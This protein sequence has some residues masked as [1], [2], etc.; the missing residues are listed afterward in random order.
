MGSGLNVYLVF[1]S[2][3]NIVYCSQPL[4]FVNVV[5][6]CSDPNLANM[7][8]LSKNF[9]GAAWRRKQSKNVYFTCVCCFSFHSFFF[10]LCPWRI[11]QSYAQII[12]LET[13]QMSSKMLQR[14]GE[15]VSLRVAMSQKKFMHAGFCV[16]VAR[17]RI[18]TARW[19]SALA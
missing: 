8:C 17:R 14:E 13:N 10:L 11:T 7:G 2:T 3:L 6:Y 12:F 16:G 19:R 15:S 4:L 18:A 9:A 1:N 5:H